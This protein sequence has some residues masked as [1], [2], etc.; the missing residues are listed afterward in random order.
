MP[1]AFLENNNELSDSIAQC[2]SPIFFSC[3]EVVGDKNRLVDNFVRATGP[4]TG[5]S[6]SGNKNVVRRNRAIG[7]GAAG[8]GHGIAVGGTGNDLRHNTALENGSFDLQD[9]NGNCAKNT[10]RFNTFVTRDPACIE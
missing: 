3:I 7:N 2:L 5:L 10:W 1:S 9:A 8:L 4:S 6:I